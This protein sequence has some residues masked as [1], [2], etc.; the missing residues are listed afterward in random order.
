[1][2]WSWRQK[3]KNGNARKE[4]ALTLIVYERKALSLA[5]RWQWLCWCVSFMRYIVYNK[6]AIYTKIS[7]FVENHTMQYA[8]YCVMWAV[9]A[10]AYMFCVDFGFVERQNDHAQSRIYLYVR[11]GWRRSVVVQEWNG[12]EQGTQREREGGERGSV[13]AVHIFIF[14]V[15]AKDITDISS[16]CH[17]GHAYCVR[18]RFFLCLWNILLILLHRCDV[19]IN[20]K[21]EISKRKHSRIY[22]SCDMH[23]TWAET[24]ERV[25]TG[26]IEYGL[27]LCWQPDGHVSL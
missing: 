26:R 21:S 19:T 24:T 12:C 22:R 9:N 2:R 13:T 27:S 4:N 25:S 6:Q 11:E 8:R 15:I 3:K 20:M 5:S 10:S 1:M 23:P 17:L 14:Y 7:A 18:F 16:R